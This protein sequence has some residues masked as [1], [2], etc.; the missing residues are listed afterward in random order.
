MMLARMAKF[1]AHLIS[2]Q[3]KKIGLLWFEMNANNRAC[4]FVW[5]S[6]L[7]LIM[8]QTVDIWI[9]LCSCNMKRPKP[10][11]WCLFHKCPILDFKT[12][13]WDDNGSDYFLCKQKDL[14]FVPGNHL[15]CEAWW[16]AHIIQEAETEDFWDSVTSQPFCLL[17]SRILRNPVQK[18]KVNGFQGIQSGIH[19]Y[20]KRV[21]K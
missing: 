11:S 8:C 12:Y 15:K 20:N 1:V 7:W 18:N 13:D 10:N 5:F 21:N 14:N 9:H 2:F 17:R 4:L 3:W 6:V 19:T 16:Y